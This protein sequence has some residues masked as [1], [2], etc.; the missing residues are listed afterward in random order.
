MYIWKGNSG[1]ECHSSL[2][3]CIIR[4]IDEQS[5][6]FEIEANTESE[7]VVDRQIFVLRFN[8]WLRS[9]IC[10]SNC[11]SN[12]EIWYQ[13]LVSLMSELVC[14]F[15]VIFWIHEQCSTGHRCHITVFSAHIE[16]DSTIVELLVVT[17]DLEFVHLS[18]VTR[19]DHNWGGIFEE[20][21]VDTRIL[22]RELIHC[23]CILK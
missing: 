21:Y 3:H 1:M 20:V 9:L 12:R 15:L 8:Q 18:V 6:L 5:V 16:V 23:L 4:S 11:L 10:L 7:V 22:G 13:F 17:F 14:L 19:L 2:N